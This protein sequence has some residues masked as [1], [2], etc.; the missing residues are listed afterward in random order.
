MKGAFKTTKTVALA[1]TILAGASVA[2]A[3]EITFLCYQDGNECDVIGEMI[4]AFTEATGHTVKMDTVG[5]DVIRDQLE[6]QLQT[7][8]APDVARVTNLGG[9]NQYY[10]LSLSPKPYIDCLNEDYLLA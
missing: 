7:N 9:L 4:P 8:A 6:N 1:T 10:L 2:Q 5:Y 3:D